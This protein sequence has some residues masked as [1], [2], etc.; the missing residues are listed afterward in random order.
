MLDVG[1]DERDREI[2]GLRDRVNQTKSEV[3]GQK[4]E[5]REREIEGP[6]GRRGVLESEGSWTSAF[7]CVYPWFAELSVRAL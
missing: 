1:G 3:R 2:E 4:S 6:S 5:V 7:I